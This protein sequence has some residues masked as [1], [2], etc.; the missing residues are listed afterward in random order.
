MNKSPVI[1][2]VET[3]GHTTGA[4]WLTRYSSSLMGVFGTPQRVLVRGAGCL[5]WDADG[6]EYLD[7]LGGIAVNALGHAHPFVTSVISS[8]LATLG[9]VSN[10]F[11]SPTQIALAEKLLATDARRRPVP[12]CSSPTPA[13]RPTRPRSSWRA[14]TPAQAPMAKRANADQDHRPRGRLPRPHHGRPRPDRQ[15]S[16]PGAVRAAA[17]R[18]GPHPVRRHRGPAWPPSMKPT[19]AV[20]LEPIQGEAGVRPLPAEL[21]AGRPRSHHQGRRPA[22]PGRG[23]DRHRPHRQ[24]ARQR[25]RRNRPRRRDPRQGPGRRLPDRRADHLRRA[26]VLAPDRRPARHHVRRKPGGHGRRPGH[27]ARHRKPAR[28]GRTCRSVGE[29]LR[30]E[31]G[32]RRRRHGSARRRPTD[33]L[34]PGRGRRARRGDRR[35]GCRVHRQQPRS[36]HHPACPAADPDQP[37][38]PT[39]SSQALPTLLQTAKDAQ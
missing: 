7:L 16:V 33:R 5:V 13:P 37:T 21:P 26:D 2:L 34:R 23:P 10:F 25:R 35:P 15:G 11:T 18:R 9:H 32:R 27:A 39:A 31:A 1:D 14:A 30:V 36:A 20:F 8:Q 4:E 29:R 22:D 17:R 38:R 3:K 12:R 6:K 28:A 19:A 24:M